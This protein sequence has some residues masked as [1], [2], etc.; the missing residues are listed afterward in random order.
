MKCEPQVEFK[1]DSDGHV[2]KCVL[3]KDIGNDNSIAGMIALD[4]F[5][6]DLGKQRDQ[7]KHERE[8]RAKRE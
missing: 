6:E 2:S 5:I 7:L 1:H 8:S 3:C 4:K